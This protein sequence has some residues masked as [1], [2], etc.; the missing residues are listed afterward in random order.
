MDECYWVGRARKLEQSA[1]G[2]ESQR[3]AS[4]LLPQNPRETRKLEPRD[5]SKDRYDESAQ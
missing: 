5:T 3:E 1:W 2:G 4:Q